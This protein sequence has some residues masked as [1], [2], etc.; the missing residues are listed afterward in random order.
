MSELKACPICGNENW[1]DERCLNCGY[2]PT[3]KQANTVKVRYVTK[4]GEVLYTRFTNEYGYSFDRFFLDRI[5]H[6]GGFFPYKGG[7]I[8]ADALL[9]IEVVEE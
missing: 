8:S 6:E 9:R 7:R 1:D 2:A 3:V 4:G 5:Q